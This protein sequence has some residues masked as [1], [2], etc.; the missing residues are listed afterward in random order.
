[1][2][3][4]KWKAN[5]PK[6]RSRYIYI[7]MFFPLCEAVNISSSDSWRWSWGWMF[8]NFLWPKNHPQNLYKIIEY[9]EWF[10]WDFQ[11]LD[12]RRFLTWISCEIGG[13]VNSL[14]ATHISTWNLWSHWGFLVQIRCCNVQLDGSFNIFLCEPTFHFQEFS[15]IFHI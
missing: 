14:W 11:R 4:I 9:N 8:L 10:T 7:Y 2:W 6:K 12:F 3:P 1:M 15:Y 5:P 13:T